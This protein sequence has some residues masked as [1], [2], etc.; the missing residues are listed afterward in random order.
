MPETGFV[1]IFWNIVGATSFLVVVLFFVF[2]LSA[3]KNVDYY[4]LSQGGGSTIS[5]PCAYAHWT[6]HLDEKAYCSDDKDKV[7]DFLAKANASLP[8]KGK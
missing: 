7:L 1:K 4:Y 8:A 2:F 5:I 3:P 6:W